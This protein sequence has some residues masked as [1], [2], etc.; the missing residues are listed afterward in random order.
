LAGP[1]GPSVRLNA[2][3]GAAPPQIGLNRDQMVANKSR[4]ELGTAYTQ[5][6]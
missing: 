3:M 5:R 6:M 2:A 4:R 1:L